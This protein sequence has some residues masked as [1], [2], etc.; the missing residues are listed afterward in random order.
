MAVDPVA[1]ARPA[2]ERACIDEVKRRGGRVLQQN[3]AVPMSGGYRMQMRV[4]MP[5]GDTRSVGCTYSTQSRKVRL[6]V[7]SST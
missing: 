7:L 3:A 1:R 5:T 2:A 4:R 6:E